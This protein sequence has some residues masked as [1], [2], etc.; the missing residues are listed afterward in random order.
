MRM[1]RAFLDGAAAVT[2]VLCCTGLSCHASDRLPQ[3]VVTR[4]ATAPV[5]DGKLDDPAWA[6]ATES[7]G[8]TVLGAH[9][10]QPIAPTF[11]KAVTDGESLYFGI[12]CMEPKLADV[13]PKA[14]KRDGD[15][16]LQE[17]VEWIID[18]T[19]EHKHFYHMIANIAE[20]Q[21]DSEISFKRDGVFDDNVKWNG[22]WELKTSQ[23]DK[24]WYAEVKI[25][26]STLGMDPAK[27]SM[28]GLAFNRAR[29]VDKG[30]LTCWSCN[31][32][33]FVEADNMGEMILPD[34]TGSYCQLKFPRLETIVTGENKVPFEIVNHSGSAI[35]PK[36][37]Y[38]FYGPK[39]MSGEVK[40][41]SVAS[42]AETSG[43]L[44]VDIE[45]PGK[46]K[47]VLTAVDAE[48]GK[49][50][51]SLSRA[52]E[53]TYPIVFDEA[54]YSMFYKRV[55]ANVSLR[56]PYD[57][58]KLKVSLLKE[59]V[60]KPLSTK[61]YEAASSV[62]VSF[63]MER[64]AR[65]KYRLSA[66]LIR[67]GKQIAK[68][69]S[70]EYPYEPNPK[71][72]FN[73]DGFLLVEGKPF[74]P[75]GIYSLQ[76]RDGSPSDAIM[77]DAKSSGMN[78]TV[79]YHYRPTDPLMPMLDAC[80]RAGL[81]AFVYPTVPFSVRKGDETPQSMK[82]DVEV[83]MKHPAIIG[84]YV[85]DEPEGIGEAPVQP[86]KDLY[87]FVKDIDQSR[88][89]SMVI[90]SPEAAKDYRECTDI[91]WI[92]PYPVPKQP[93]TLVSDAV[94]GAIANIERDK[95][96]WC[97]VQAF[98]WSV[99]DNGKLN[100]EH[101]PTADEE[102]CMTYMALVNGA[103]GIIYWAYGSSKYYT[104]D[105]PQHWLDVKKVT[106]EVHELTPVLL[107]KTVENRLLTSNGKIQSMLK[108][109]NG[110]WYVLA[111]NSSRE[112]CASTFKLT[113]IVE[114][115]NID[116]KFEN[117]SLS[118]NASGWTDSFKPLEVHVYKLS[119]K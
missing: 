16:W 28:A 2:L 49:Q 40:M 76:A 34:S 36:L 116:V 23:G 68:N 32:V 13:R 46:Y 9:E 17:S 30:E 74:F 15:T 96:L 48:T 73:K 108:K 21:F 85:V 117:R 50:L 63:D 52:V 88:P 84:W 42:N 100:G 59:G 94:S 64:H 5:M 44:P 58:A 79:L 22:E 113:G 65:G 81:K 51:Y 70:I 11:V 102:R 54:F 45:T 90:M 1:L 8:F 89:C 29:W 77:Q 66:E 25:P 91:M 20:C 101:R 112:G 24:V 7:G 109:Y 27:V 98:D 10:K 103:K 80:Q 87:K 14:D 83:R 39:P 67:G 110:D 75:L 82:H 53:A 62:K 37:S 35:H 3:L 12:R 69:T 4:V 115:A 57:D 55:D 38:T 104:A 111:V 18:P 119:A 33:K 118:A 106:G 95:P 86:V 61:V 114:G 56:V 43:V 97:I 93:I 105:Y 6:Q 60:S 72:G 41:D 47:L 31:R 92:D 99:W 26:F 78:T 19:N 107:T 71:V